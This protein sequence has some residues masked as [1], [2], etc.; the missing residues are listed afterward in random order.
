MNFFVMTKIAGKTDSGDDMRNA[1]TV[2]KTIDRW[3]CNFAKR[4]R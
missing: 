1:G 2:E 3:C 4:R